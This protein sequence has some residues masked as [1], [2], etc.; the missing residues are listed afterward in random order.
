MNVTA[1]PATKPVSASPRRVAVGVCTYKRMNFLARCLEHVAVTARHSGEHVEVIVVD[2]DGQDPAVAELVGRAS[3]STGVPMHYRIETTPGIAAARNAVF[4]EA[5][6][7]GISMMAMLDDDE[8]PSEDW[9]AALLRRQHTTGAVVVGGPV[10]PVFPDSAA[11]LRRWAR[12]WSV[13][14]Q[15]LDGKPFVFCSCNFLVH[16]DAIADEPR[17]LFDGEFGLSGGEDTVFF[18]KLFYRGHPMAWADDALMYEEV[19]PDRAKLAWMRKRRYGVGNHAVRWEGL[20]GRG[21]PLIK[22][23]GLSVR[24]LFYPLL[25][26]EPESP[27]M[28]WLL[29][30]DKVRGRWAGH[31]G[32][33]HMGYA[34]PDGRGKACD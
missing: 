9:L 1:T 6:R 3:A 28:G 29:E 11:R 23:C 24:L 33:V 5:T 32:S 16:L 17:P 21:N 7:R 8:W 14:P 2:N 10:R 34:R 15:F 13:E 22:T 25:R 26:R 27:W 4:D 12:Y 31:L 30:A 20:H 19:P 18:R